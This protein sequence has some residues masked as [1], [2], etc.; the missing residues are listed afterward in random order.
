MHSEFRVVE[1][2]IGVQEQELMKDRKK[3]G[4]EMQHESR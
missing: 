2:L 1:I 3:N 4:E